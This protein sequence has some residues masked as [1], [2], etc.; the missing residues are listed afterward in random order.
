MLVLEEKKKKT[1]HLLYVH[2]KYLQMNGLIFGIFCKTTR[3]VDGCSA[4]AR[5]A[6]SVVVRAGDGYREVHH[7]RISTLVF[8]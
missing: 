1:F 8:L 4:E 5:V 2:F 3:E 7:M 6:V